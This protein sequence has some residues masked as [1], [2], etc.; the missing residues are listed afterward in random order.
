VNIQPLE[1]GQTRELLMMSFYREEV[2]RA[3]F[4]SQKISGHEESLSAKKNLPPIFS[5][6]VHCPLLSAQYA[7]MRI[8]RYPATFPHKDFLSHFHQSS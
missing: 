7:Q 4:F 6:L 2:G 8:G 3:P 1:Q 5:S